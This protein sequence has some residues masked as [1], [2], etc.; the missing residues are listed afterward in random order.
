MRDIDQDHDPLDVIEKWFKGCCDGLWEHH[1][2]LK[3]ETTDNPG[4]LM[5]IDKLIDESVFD[6]MSV[7]VRKRW[8]A[9]CVR[10]QG[11]SKDYAVSLN[12]PPVQIIK[13]KQDKIKVYAVSLKDCV[14]AG[15][16]ILQ[17]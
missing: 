1:S 5:T 2:G 10:E 11:T 17:H 3:L 8:G 4:W 6:D 7:E 14:C 13:L 12:P 9:E 16:Y 15:A